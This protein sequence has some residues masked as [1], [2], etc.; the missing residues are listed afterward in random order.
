MLGYDLLRFT[1]GFLGLI[2]AES[3]S[4]Q[5]LLGFDRL[6]EIADGFC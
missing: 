6:Q 1:T 5:D 3:L 2:V 4:E